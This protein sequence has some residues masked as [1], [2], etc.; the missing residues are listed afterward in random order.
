MFLVPSL[1]ATAYA[2]KLQRFTDADIFWQ[3]VHDSKSLSL[4]HTHTHT[5]AH[6]HTHTHTHTRTSFIIKMN[7]NIT[8]VSFWYGQTDRR[9]HTHTFSLSLRSIISSC[10]LIFYWMVKL[11]MKYSER[12]WR[13]TYIKVKKMIV[14]K[15]RATFQYLKGNKER[16][17]F[18]KHV[19]I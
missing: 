6:A 15:R 5:H 8:S 13:W 16:L 7:E 19:L 10:R 4:T 17:K 9:T 11:Q 14:N 2:V 18:I 1:L 12:H 3:Q